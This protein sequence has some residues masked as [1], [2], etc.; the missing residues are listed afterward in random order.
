MRTNN[1]L[2][3]LNYKYG[4][5]F[6]S[7]SSFVHLVL[8]IIVLLIF[9]RV[10]LH[11]SQLYDRFSDIFRTLKYC[12]I[13]LLTNKSVYVPFVSA[14]HTSLKQSCQKK[15]GVATGSAFIIKVKMSIT[16]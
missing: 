3:I 11:T 14:L 12:P 9:R 2:I 13:Y 7:F 15:A 1:V 16:V 4:G 10:N 8:L 5:V 6:F